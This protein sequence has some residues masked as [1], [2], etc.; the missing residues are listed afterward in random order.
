MHLPALEERS[1]LDDT[2]LFQLLADRDEKDATAIRMRELPAAEAHGDLQLVAFIEEFRGGTDLRVDVVV[3]DLRR[4]PDLLPRD[5]LLLL[6]G[7][8][9]FLLKVV[10]VLSEVAHA[11]HRRLD[12]RGDLDEVV[13][14]LLRLRERARRRDDPEL[15][16]I[17]TEEANS[18]NTDRFVDPQFGRGYRETSVSGVR[19]PLAVRPLPVK[20]LQL[21]R[22]YHRAK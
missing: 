21:R 22:A 8:L 16:A 20:Q 13:A 3:V 17:G 2:M 1:A 18:R 7:I 4:D 11:R 5:G 10:P 19:M 6:L 9:G 12:V 15:L 14:F